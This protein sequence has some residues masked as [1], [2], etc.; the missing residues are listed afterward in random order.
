MGQL[1]ERWRKIS[2]SVP[3]KY[4]NYGFWMLIGISMFQFLRFEY[5]PSLDGPQHL[6]NAYV[7][8][9][10]I[11]D[12]GDVRDFY[13]INPL[14]VG[15][16]TAHTLLTLFTFIFPPWLAEKLLILTYVA[17][18]ALA[19]RYFLRSINKNVNPVGLYLIFPFIPSLFILHGYYSFSFGFIMLFVTLGYWNRIGRNPD[20]IAWV[21]FSL[22]LL[23][24]YFTHGLVFTFFLGAFLIQYLYESVI[25][26]M[27]R[28]IN[29]EDL[30]K[31]GIR[32]LKMMFA[33]VPVLIVLFI[34]SRSV[35]S[36]GSGFDPNPVG[37]KEQLLQLF[38]ITP[39]I[40]FHHEMES[41]YTKPLFLC[42]MGVVFFILAS[43]LVRI[44]SGKVSPRTIILDKSNV[45]LLISLLFLFVYLLDP[46]RFFSG[47]MNMRVGFLFFLFLIMWIPFKRVPALVNLVM[48][49]VILFAVIYHQALMP[50]FYK[51]QVKLILELQELDPFIDDGASVL[52]LRESDN[53][54]HG[55]FGLY[56]GLNKHTINLNNPQCYGPFPLIW[57]RENSS[58]FFAG[59]MQVK[60]TG[61]GRLDPEL[62]PSRQV[63]YIVVFFH[64]KYMEKKENEVWKDI[65]E[66]EYQLLKL[67]SNKSAG[68]YSK[69]E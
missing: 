51:P 9:D 26:W 6:H 64:D 53:W 37:L 62:Y 29:G 11:F 27:E 46:D 63:D 30:P 61:L 8:K 50:Y 66:N 68:L 57:D 59:D 7:L 54:L 69:I 22:L 48:G 44:W 65:L 15:Y 17:G 23:L 19:F 12:R 24:F 32:A 14:P 67:T 55:H 52:V 47:S 18:M 34:Y 20:T 58:A 28:K 60:V 43:G 1:F 4:Y 56:L 40:G 10:L 21:K 33:F 16:W 45:Y 25:D 41:V 3:G 36:M 2:D 13:N 5:I 39:I 42:L 49:M 38:R 31:F 35:F